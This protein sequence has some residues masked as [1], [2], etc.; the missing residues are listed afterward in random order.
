MLVVLEH[1]Y[2]FQKSPK[3]CHH[4]HKATPY[5]FVRYH[6]SFMVALL[7]QRSSGDAPSRTCFRSLAVFA[8][9]LE[10][11][12]PE[13]TFAP[14]RQPPTVR[15][16]QLQMVACNCFLPK[17]SYIVPIVRLNIFLR[18]FGSPRCSC[19]NRQIGCHWKWPID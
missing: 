8:G 7:V 1:H 13:R 14:R 12:T 11:K 6:V 19:T 2:F 5:V 10:K 18:Y 9:I 15:T 4:Q 16:D 17:K 3:G